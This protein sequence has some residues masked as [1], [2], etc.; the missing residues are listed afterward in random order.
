MTFAFL[1]T[2]VGAFIG[3]AIGAVIT[4]A[5]VYAVFPAGALLTLLG[6]AVLLAARRMPLGAAGETPT[7]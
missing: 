4:R 1:P 3:P 6:I 2:N 5:T 7:A